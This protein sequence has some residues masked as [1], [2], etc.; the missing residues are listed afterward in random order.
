MRQTVLPGFL[1]FLLN[2]GHVKS[3]STDQYKE[4]F[5]MTKDCLSHDRRGPHYLTQ[6]EKY[7]VTW[8][9]E[10]FFICMVLFE[11]RN[12]ANVDT[13]YN[14]CFRMLQNNNFTD[15]GVKLKYYSTNKDGFK[16]DIIYTCG[17][18]VPTEWCST[19]REG[20]LYLF[21]L[22]ATNTSFRIEVVAYAGVSLSKLACV[23]IA[24]VSAATIVFLIIIITWSVRKRN[25]RSD[26]TGQTLKVASSLQKPE[27]EQ[28]LDQK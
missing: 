4:V 19:S 25:V 26:D 3:S 28:H 21:T 17:Q 22:G 7:L 10:D 18:N 5:T 2:F 15:C 1:V 23:G 24:I 9:G 8:D 11:A 6:Y 12:E 27:E 20:R 13:D 16:P 14:V